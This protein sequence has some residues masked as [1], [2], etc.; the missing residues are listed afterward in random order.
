MGV[1]FVT[2]FSSHTQKNNVIM[3][4]F[5]RLRTNRG[6]GEVVEDEVFEV[7][8]VIRGESGNVDSPS[9]SVE[10]ADHALTAA[11]EDMR[12]DHGSTH[13]LMTEQ[14]LDGADVGTRL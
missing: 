8:V 11:I 5:R 13:V 1:L 6:Y 14:F 10:W 3:R 2:T 4:F 7:L 12:I 9:Y